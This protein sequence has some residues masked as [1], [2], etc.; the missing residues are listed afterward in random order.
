MNVLI[1]GGTGLLGLEAARQLL[2]KKHHVTGIALPPL[3]SGVVLP[4]DYGIIYENY[5]AM[6]D[7]RLLELLASV[8]GLVFAAG[9]DERLEGA[10]PIYDMYDKYN[11]QPVRRLLELGSRAGLKKVV[12]LG[13]YFAYAH[14]MHPEWH[15]DFDHPYIRS[16]LVQEEVALSFAASG[17]MDVAVLE[18]PYIFGTQPGRQP[19]WTVLFEQILAMKRKTYYPKGGT[20][21]V[22]VTQVGQ[23]IVGALTRNKGGNRY[24][25]GYHNMAWKEMLALF[26]EAAGISRPIVTVPTWMYQLG[27][28]AIAAKKKKAGIDM[29]LHMPKFTKVMTSELFIDK[30]E[31]AS[32][33]GVKPDDIKAAIRQSAAQSILALKT[34]AM[35][36][37]KAE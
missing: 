23:A 19:V 11:I 5:L 33:L 12:I 17:K 8:Q 1:I 20:A 37:M 36:T 27:I 6:S 35:V 14:R 9:I 29:G 31:G 7:E 13:S 28:M 34:K 10:A 18:L 25:I 30:A 15:L 4:P 21:M 26:H 22:T 32:F 2:A 16:R 24:P 3:P